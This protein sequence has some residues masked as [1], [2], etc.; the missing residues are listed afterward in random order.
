MRGD[1]VVEEAPDL[2]QYG[3][4]APAV[5]VRVRLADQTTREILFGGE[6]P[7]GGFHYTRLGSE[8]GVFLTAATWRDLFLEEADDLRDRRLVVFEPG[9]VEGIT[10]STGVRLVLEAGAWY[11]EGPP[12]LRADDT[13]VATFLGRLQTAR[14]TGFAPPGAALSGIE[15][16]LH[17]TDADADHVLVF[18]PPAPDAAD[19]VLAGDLSREPVFIVGADLRDLAASRPAHWRDRTILDLDPDAVRSIT[20]E[21]GEDTI[22]LEKSADEWRL[23]GGGEAVSTPAVRDMLEAFDF[24]RAAEVIDRP[25]ALGAYGLEN[26]EIRVVFGMAAGDDIAFAFGSAAPN[27][28]LYWQRQGE[29]AVRRV[30]APVRAPFA[31]DLATL[32]GAP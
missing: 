25:G 4:E 1:P 12:R 13:E 16:R 10:I 2:A 5:R 24:R 28:T 23:A 31:A 32:T 30:P 26:P 27:D 15:V 21:R 6:N 8:P 20:L 11:L 18:G 19:G 17:A 7:A 14:A 3:L 9:A 22:L 29:D